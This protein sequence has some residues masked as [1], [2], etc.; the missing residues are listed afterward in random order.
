MSRNKVSL[1]RGKRKSARARKEQKRSGGGGG[2][3]PWKSPGDG[4]RSLVFCPPFFIF[5]VIALI[6]APHPNW[7]SPREEV[8]LDRLR[9]GEL[10][11]FHIRGGYVAERRPLLTC[12]ARTIAQMKLWLFIYTPPFLSAPGSARSHISATLC[13]PSVLILPPYRVFS[14]DRRCLSASSSISSFKITVLVHTWSE[15]RFTVATRRDAF[16]AVDCFRAL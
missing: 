3:R 7:L 9:Q 11:G 10:W 15:M 8:K 4:V 6:Y 14:P 1:P 12:L 13:I 16:R 5:R 2:G